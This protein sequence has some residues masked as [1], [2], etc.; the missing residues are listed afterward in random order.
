MTKGKGCQNRYN[1]AINLALQ[2]GGS[3]GACCWGV[4][5]RMFAEDRLWVEA[6]WATSAGAMNAVVAAQGMYDG[7]ADC[8]RSAV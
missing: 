2:G 1:R 3:Q 5:D 4:M 8:G 6:I 7:G